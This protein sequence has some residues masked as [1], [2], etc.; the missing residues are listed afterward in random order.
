MPNDESQVIQEY[1]I[2][3]TYVSIKQLQ[4]TSR[5]IYITQNRVIKTYTY[6]QIF[7][8]VPEYREKLQQLGGDLMLVCGI[9]R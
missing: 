9:I 3:N 5:K 7:Q 2:L 8:Y 1:I 6:N 4:K